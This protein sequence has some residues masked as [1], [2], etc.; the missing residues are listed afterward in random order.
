MQLIEEKE[1]H[2]GIFNTLY[3]INTNYR[4]NYELYNFLFLFINQIKLNYNGI[5]S[6]CSTEIF[7]D[8]IE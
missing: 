1:N 5:T 8:K 7:L 3:T 6:A 4:M 2:I